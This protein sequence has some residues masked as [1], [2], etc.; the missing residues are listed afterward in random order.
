VPD[1]DAPFFSS[2]GNEIYKSDRIGWLRKLF[3]LSC[4]EYDRIGL[5]NNDP[6]AMMMSEVEK[7]LDGVKEAE[8]RN[9]LGRIERQITDWSKGKKLYGPIHDDLLVLKYLH[10]RYTNY[11]RWLK[12]RE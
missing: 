5:D 2:P 10:Q 12:T 3:D 11:L 8:V 4:R 7:G 6:V 1:L 9:R